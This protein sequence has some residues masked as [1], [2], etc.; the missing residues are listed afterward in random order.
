MT[1]QMPQG[2]QQTLP[3]AIPA[4][5]RIRDVIDFYAVTADLSMEGV[6]LRAARIPRQGEVLECRIRNVEPFEG[7]VVHVS[8]TDF[9]LKVGGRSP[10]AVARQLLEAARMQAASEAPVRT[11]RRIVPDASGIVVTLP[12]A[13]IVQARI[14]NVSASGVAV[15]TTEPVAVGALV[16][17]GSTHARVMRVFGNGFGAAFLR[18]FDPGAVDETLIL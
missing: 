9:T 18:P 15:G 11:H 17:V 14:L 13:R 8:A 10:G 2:S 3:V 1:R 16:V 5:C 4:F 6:R 7:R 12:D